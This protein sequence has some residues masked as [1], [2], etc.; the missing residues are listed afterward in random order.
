MKY[1]A[2]LALLGAC[3]I[4][5]YYGGD[6][7]DG[8]TNGSGTSDGSSTPAPVPQSLCGKWLPTMAAPSIRLDGEMD[9]YNG[10]GSVDSGVTVELWKRGGSQPITTATTAAGKYT[11]YAL[12]MGMPLDAYIHGMMPGYVDTYYF[13]ETPFVKNELIHGLSVADRALFSALGP[14][15]PNTGVVL[16]QMLGCETEYTNGATVTVS[17]AGTV[18]YLDENGFRATP[19][20]ATFSAF[21]KDVPAGNITITVT[22]SPRPMRTGYAVAF[23]NSITTIDLSPQ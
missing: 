10:M 23:A 8:G 9:A 22:G 20:A 11:L 21:I 13:P 14:W 3:T 16:L 15:A 18:M 17:P 12:T 1:I 7:P 5:N 6:P 4:E 19:S 2:I